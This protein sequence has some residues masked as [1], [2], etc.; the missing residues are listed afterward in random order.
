[1]VKEIYDKHLKEVIATKV[2]HDLPE[3]FGIPE[4]TKDYIQ[5]SIDMPFFAAYE[6]DE[7][8]GFVTLKET[9]TYTAEIYCMGVIK[10]AHRK[11]YGQLLLKFF[12]SYAKKNHYKMLQV[13]TVE[14]GKYEIY[15]RTNA[16]Y[17]ACG[18]LELEVFPKLWDEWNPCQ[19]FV[20]MID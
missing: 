2:L 16:F 15:D 19:I 12:E 4:Y 3:W 14:E 6:G 11:G 9:S 7:V 1:M 17:R 18:F 10:R 13:K 20:K 8:V 5:K